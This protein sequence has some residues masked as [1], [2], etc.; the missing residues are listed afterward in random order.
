MSTSFETQC[1]NE[2][3]LHNL[4]QNKINTDMSTQ[5]KKPMYIETQR[6]RPIVEIRK[7]CT[8]QGYLSMEKKKK[9]EREGKKN[10]E[11]HQIKQIKKRMHI[12]RNSH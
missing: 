6:L 4:K 5:I 1:R 8:E 12:T 9:E 10:E 2:T 7:P 11:I 3:C